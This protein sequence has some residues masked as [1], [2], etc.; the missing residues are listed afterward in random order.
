MFE[1]VSF[2]IYIKIF[3]AAKTGDVKKNGQ[4]IYDIVVGSETSLETKAG[5]CL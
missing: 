1:H 4:K 2:C 5:L 3:L